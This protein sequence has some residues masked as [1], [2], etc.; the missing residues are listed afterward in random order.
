[1]A[2]ERTRRG[3]KWIRVA[4]EK[5]SGPEIP[6][7]FG[8][9]HSGG[10]GLCLLHGKVSVF[11]PKIPMNRA[12]SSLIVVYPL[13]IRAGGSRGDAH[14]VR[15]APVKVAATLARLCGRGQPRSW[16]ASAALWGIRA[17]SPRSPSEVGQSVSN[18][19]CENQAM[20]DN[21]ITV[22]GGDW[23]RN[24]PGGGRGEFAW[25]WQGSAVPDRAFLIRV[26]R[27]KPFWPFSTKVRV[28]PSGSDL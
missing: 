1:L 19:P 27:V 11:H 16:S 28:S 10:G 26:I 12:E 9:F 2:G 6:V 23:R 7:Y 3:P 4:I 17:G 13:L 20:N 5:L 22:G 18:P 8:P 25:S 14:A 24:E 21:F 15:S